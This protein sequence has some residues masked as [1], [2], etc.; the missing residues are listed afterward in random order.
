MPQHNKFKL[1]KENKKIFVFAGLL[2]ILLIGAYFTS[3]DKTEHNFN[4]NKI[5]FDLYVMSQ[6]PYGTQAEKVVAQAMDDF[7]DYVNF[8]VEYI[9]S[10]DKDGQLSSLHGE[11]EVKGDKYQ[12]CV[13]K[14]F[15]DKFWPYLECQNK[16]Y[17]DL[18][19]TF[20]SCAQDN[21]I[22][23]TA[24]KKCAEGKEGQQLLKTSAQKAAKLKVSG[25]PTF[26]IDGKLYNGPRTVIA[27]QRDLCSKL[28]NAPQKCS[29]LPEEKAFT[30][31]L[32]FD[33]RCNKPEC[34]TSRL[35]QQLKSTFAKIKFKKID[36]T[37]KD[38]ENFYKKY[39][40]TYLPAVLFSAEVKKSDNYP[41]VARYLKENNDLY[42]LA[43][44]A[45]Y[46]PTKEICD[47]KKDDTNNGLVDCADPDC[48]EAMVCRQETKNTLDLFVMSHCPYGTKGLD[49]MKEVL[50]NFGKDI[51][52]NIHYIATEKN[53]GSF[54]S[55][56]GQ[57]EVDEDIRELCAKKY[58][59]HNYMDYIW[60]RNKD[61]KGDWTKC[62]AN[63]SK[64]NQCFKSNEGKQLLAKN[65]KLADKLQI[66]A[67]PTWLVNNKYL[68]NG[69]DAQTV[70][71]NFC[72]YNQL[73]ACKNTLT[74]NNNNIPAGSCN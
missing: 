32:I 13:K 14:Y 35:E 51:K 34:D 68:F 52:F 61:I 70:K 33:S 54:Q 65:I 2:I 7:K 53:D 74:G 19:K 36:Y 30:A 59:P 37:S 29:Q 47:N 22:D 64:I 17:R 3:K 44:G 10:S 24:L 12:L 48:K 40:L 25:S 72:K 45:K 55:L 50:D 69:I 66:G 26:Y 43:I 5:N 1:T 38:G 23:F 39:N 49:A 27:I 16:N 15:P 71:N 67:S 63:F 28:N 57:P 60:C 4:G 73:A 8:N 56:H 6:C 62:A 58:Y 31:Y 46:D 41:Q 20:E 18:E 9:A 11:K 21:Q 42:N